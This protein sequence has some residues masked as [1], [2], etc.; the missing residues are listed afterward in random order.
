MPKGERRFGAVPLYLG[1]AP[2]SSRS[3][4]HRSDLLSA[5]DGVIFEEAWPRRVVENRT[6]AYGQRAPRAIV[7]APV[8]DV[9]GWLDSR[10]SSGPLAPPVA[11]R[12]CGAV[13]STPTIPTVIVA[14]EEQALGDI[15]RRYWV[16]LVLQFGSSVTGKTHARSD[17]DLA[18]QRDGAPLSFRE[19]AELVHELQA[20]FPNH[21]IDLALLNRADPLFLKQITEACRLLYGDPRDLQRLRIFAFGS[22][23]SRTPFCA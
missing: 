15:A 6:L 10:R 2:A 13:V 9:P 11:T 23:S 19:H 1:F 22:A 16:K 14:S 8:D 17:I 5:I 20:L 12:R 21:E 18:I 3:S 7:A 4:P